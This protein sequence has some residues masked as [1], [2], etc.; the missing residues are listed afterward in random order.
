MLNPKAQGNRIPHFKSKGKQTKKKSEGSTIQKIPTESLRISSTVSEVPLPSAYIQ[1][2]AK[3][4]VKGK[5]A[6]TA[7]KSEDRL[8]IS[9][10]ATTT[11]PVSK[12]FKIK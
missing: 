10:I 11:A 8:E 2:K 7:A 6:K 5:D 4:E 12:A 1:T 9:E 3:S